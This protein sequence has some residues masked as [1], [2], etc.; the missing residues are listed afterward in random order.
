MVRNHFSQW[1]QVTELASSVL[2]MMHLVANFPA[3]MLEP[4][5][6]MQPLCNPPLL[7]PCLMQCTLLSNL[8]CL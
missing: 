4:S 7:M 6:R 3:D 8:L 1:G 5:L 2:Q